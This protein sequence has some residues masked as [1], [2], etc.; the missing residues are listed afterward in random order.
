MIS[1]VFLLNTFTL[2]SFADF[3]LETENHLGWETCL[4][5][6]NLSDKNPVGRTSFL[7]Q[8]YPSI[9]PYEMAGKSDGKLVLKGKLS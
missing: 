3:I 5:M 7:S 2:I 4:K 9:F 1:I 8:I 6:E